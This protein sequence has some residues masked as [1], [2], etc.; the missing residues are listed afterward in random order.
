MEFGHLLSRTQDSFW[1]FFVKHPGLWYNWPVRYFADCCACPLPSFNI[2][3]QYGT[4]IYMYVVIILYLNSKIFIRRCSQVPTLIP[5]SKQNQA[6]VKL[7]SSRLN[8]NWLLTLDH[9][10]HTMDLL[11]THRDG[12]NLSKL[13]WNEYKTTD[14]TM[15]QDCFYGPCLH[16]VDSHVV[17]ILVHLLD[18]IYSTRVAIAIGI[19]RITQTNIRLYVI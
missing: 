14:I 5:Y 19:F 2:T 1:R 17:V 9:F 10:L 7:V 3:I 13:P 16:L 11:W 8:S 18:S 4:S 6:A 15:A 12:R